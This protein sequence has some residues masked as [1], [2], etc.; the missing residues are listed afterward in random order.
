MMMNDADDGNSFVRPTV[1]KFS[2]NASHAIV[3]SKPISWDTAVPLLLLRTATG[4]AALGV[5]RWYASSYCYL[6]ARRCHVGCLHLY[7]K[8][9]SAIAGRRLS[10]EV[11]CNPGWLNF[12]QRLPFSLI[13]RTALIYYARTVIMIMGCAHYSATRVHRNFV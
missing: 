11:F 13:H 7:Q 8:Q 5:H 9:T 2:S 3:D 10:T 12:Q 6:A 1:T 4:S